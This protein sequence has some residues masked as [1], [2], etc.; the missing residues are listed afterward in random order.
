[1]ALVTSKLKSQAVS[2]LPL[3][4]PTLFKRAVAAPRFSHDMG[5]LISPWISSFV[6]SAQVVAATQKQE[7]LLSDCKPSR[8]QQQSQQD[9]C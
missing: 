4:T 6:G 8:A 3:E 2:V 9:G 5:R 1:M 7:V